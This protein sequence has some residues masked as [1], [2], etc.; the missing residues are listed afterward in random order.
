LLDAR[1]EP[2][3]RGLADRVFAA[4]REHLP[5]G[6]LRRID[7]TSLAHIDSVGQSLGEPFRKGGGIGDTK[8]FQQEQRPRGG[9][10]IRVAV[11]SAAM[12]A[13]AAGAMVAY[14]RSQPAP[15]GDMQ[16][17]DAGSTPTPDAADGASADRDGINEG[18]HRASAAELTLVAFH[19]PNAS[20]MWLSEESLG[21]SDA[22]A[23]AAPVL[24]THGAELDD[25]EG[26]LG[27]ILGLSFAS[28]PGGAAR[29]HDGPKSEA[30]SF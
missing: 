4:S 28:G 3:P 12:I 25:I 29:L 16:V 21:G 8:W 17:A 11:A 1:H 10:W 24:R 15:R 30:G 26:E 18:M 27:E 22:A 23:L 20:R 13:V 5:D 19:N 2:L 14:Q 6:V 7:E 9:R